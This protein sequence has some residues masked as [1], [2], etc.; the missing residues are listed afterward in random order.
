V[1]TTVENGSAP[2]IDLSWQP[3]SDADLSGYIVYRRET[4]PLWQR[5]SPSEP[6]IAPAFRDSQVQ[7]G[8]SYRYAVTG[9]SQSG[10]ESARSAEAEES[11]PNP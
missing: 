6:L 11:V 4:E 8:H 10:H 1:A 5:I 9:I 3:V 7:P 2:A